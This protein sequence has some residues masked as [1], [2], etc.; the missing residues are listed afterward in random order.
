MKLALVLVLAAACGA[1]QPTP[2]PQPWG[3]PAK[4]AGGPPPPS[5]AGP[6]ASCRDTLACYTQCDPITDACLA[7]CD[8]DGN[9]S[10]ISSARAILSCIVQSG[11]SD[12][13]CVDQRC[14]TEISACGQTAAAEPGPGPTPGPSPSTSLNVTYSVP[15]GWHESAIDGGVI[16]DYS[17]Q[18]QPGTDFYGVRSYKVA[19]LAPIAVHGSLAATFLAAWDDMIV[20]NM[21]PTITP[22]PM[23]RRLPGGAAVAYDGARATLANG[24]ELQVVLYLVAAGDQAVPVIG[25]YNDTNDQGEATVVAL[26]DGI[27]IPGGSTTRVDLYT[28]KELAGDWSTSS[29]SIADYTTATGA[30]AGDASIS[31]GETYKLAANGT[32]TSSFVGFQGN[33]PVIKESS[34]GK[35]SVDDDS[36]V[37]VAKGKTTRI[38]IFAVGATGVAM[39]QSYDGAAYNELIVP[40][41][42]LAME[43][44]GPAK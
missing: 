31:T 39:P 44:Y 22:A 32:F 36:L 6:G 17:E 1:P 37:L 28:A 21:K 12:E 18:E 2:G 10:T 3:T 26:L 4:T 29:Y 8:K 30:Y 20:P 43:W 27:R 35:W 9:S 5:V 23:R 33:G 25:Y 41:R 40:R 13:G 19:I 42:P 14:A 24:A 11:C 15:A 38:R 16:L 34:A 7:A